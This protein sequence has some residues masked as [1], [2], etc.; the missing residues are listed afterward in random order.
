MT[1]FTSREFNQSISRAKK[2]ALGGPVFVTDRGKP[3]HVLLSYD[4]YQRLT[5]HSANIVEALSM[6]GLSDVDFAPEP[7]S[8]T[9]KPVDLS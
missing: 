6:P 9:L 8:I 5:S 7:S 3:S 2:D 4:E 1:H